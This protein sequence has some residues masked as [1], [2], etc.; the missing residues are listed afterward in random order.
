MLMTAAITRIDWLGMTLRVPHEWAIVK[1]A[2]SPQR[3][4]LA[5]V[6]RRRQR[7]MLAWS[8][9]PD[10]P[11]WDRMLSDQESLELEAHPGASFERS[12]EQGWQVLRRSDEGSGVTR[13]AR[14]D[15][16][17]RRVIE[18]VIPVNEPGDAEDELQVLTGF[19]VAPVEEGAGEAFCA[20]DLSIWV[21]SGWRL[22]KVAVQ[23]GQVEVVHEL[24]RA[25]LTVRRLGMAESWLRGD[26]GSYLRQQLKLLKA[27][28][29]A[30][31]WQGQ[32]AWSI[33]RREPGPR[34]KAIL[35]RLRRCTE[36]VWLQPDANALVHATLMRPRR[37]TLS[38]EDFDIACLDAWNPDA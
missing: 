19:D 26:A 32:P 7:L 36:L 12:V 33:D 35:G 5:L 31:T 3:G 29:M 28:T 30:M 23:P 13:A 15:R 25:S 1:H 11:D 20:F 17:R 2:V 18:L 34:I 14:Y 21:P 37:Q 8:P 9:C 6:D 24:G 10:S 38:L 22:A 27:Q 16:A 4:R